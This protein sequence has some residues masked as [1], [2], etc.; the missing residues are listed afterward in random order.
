MF[1]ISENSVFDWFILICITLNA[2][3]MSMVHLGITSDFNLALT[4]AN[5]FFTGIF[6]FEMVIRLIAYGKNYFRDAWNV[7]DF[8][9][10]IGSSIFIGISIFGK[11]SNLTTFVTAARLLRIGRLL[12]LFRQMKSL[13]MIFSTFLS[14]LPHML[15]VGGIMILIIYI[16]SVIGISLFA[17]VKPNGGMHRFLGFQGFYKSFITLIRIAT[18]E[19]WNQLMNSL[20]R[21]N[22]EDFVCIDNPTYEDFKNADFKPQGCGNP[23]LA[24]VFFITYI[25]LVGLIFLNLFI[26]I[27]LQGYYQATEMEKQ[28][29]N[30]E[31]M[32]KYRDAWAQFDQDATG[33]ME[34]NRF[35]DLMLAFGPP[36]G[37]DHTFLNKP[38]KQAL[39]FRLIS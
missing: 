25:F 34:A 29:V 9:I 33:F 8:T 16:Y 23:F 7:F 6:F 22:S 3:V 14:T 17:E 4:I 32:H 10:V 30:S 21:I 28:V 39:F 2:I 35:S 5:Y 12:R 1:S 24:Q 20:S 27:I 18:G 19:N 13:Q 31:I 37:W 36:L 38:T 15:N 11:G 26:A